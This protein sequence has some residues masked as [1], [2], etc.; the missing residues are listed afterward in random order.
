MNRFHLSDGL[1]RLAYSIYFYGTIGIAIAL[2]GA[3]LSNQILGIDTHAVNISGLLGIAV[4]YMTLSFTLRVT[5]EYMLFRANAL[6]LARDEVSAAKTERNL[7]NVD[8]TDPVLQG[9]FAR[10]VQSQDRTIRVLDLTERLL[11]IID[12]LLPI[13]YAIFCEYVL[14]RSVEDFFVDLAARL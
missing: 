1:R 6:Q 3:N 8:I 13:S 5:N 4:L 9:I 2:Y 11:F 12:L 10:I 14:G 7:L